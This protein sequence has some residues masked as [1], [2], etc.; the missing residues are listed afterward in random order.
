MRWAAA[1]ALVVLVLLVIGL[2][3]KTQGLPGAANAAALVSLIPLG[4]GL[5]GW[6]RNRRGA[7][8]QADEGTADLGQWL[9][10]IA[11]GKGLTRQD[12]RARMQGWSGEQVDAYLDGARRPEWAFM[13]AFIAVVAGREPWHREALERMIRPVWNASDAAARS[14]DGA[15]A[16]A[17][18]R[19][20]SR[21][22]REWFAALG[23]VVATRQVLRRVEISVR[24]HE[25]LA[26]ALGEM[27]ARLSQAVT[28]LAAQRDAQSRRQGPRPDGS[29]GE[30]S[31]GQAQ[32]GA[33]ELR[34]EQQETQRRLSEAERLRVATVQ[35][36]NVSEGQRHHAEQL[37][38]RVIAQAEQARR[39]LAQL[40]SHPEPIF[41]QDAEILQITDNP[42]N[43]LMGDTD[44][45]MAEEILDRVDSVL[46]DEA[47]TLGQLGE[48]L[49]GHPAPRGIARDGPGAPGRRIM[50]P[51][52]VAVAA[53][54]AIIAAGLLVTTN[55]GS[56]SGT[57]PGAGSRS[58]SYVLPLGQGSNFSYF[59]FDLG[60]Q[61]GSRA[62]A[63]VE[64]SYNL[65]EI[66]GPL[67]SI[68]VHYGIVQSDVGKQACYYAA[69]GST[70]GGT[71][72]SL[73]KGLRFCVL[74][75]SGVALMEI[76]QTPGNSGPLDLRE[77][78]WPGASP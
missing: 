76:T 44:R 69:D 70:E 29:R 49:T 64:A 43:V 65:S 33:A 17:G 11:D 51:R 16:A 13:A 78:D 73:Y 72:D 27:L 26:A 63:Q 55:I 52:L 68:Y 36:L 67:F 20:V 14:K 23:N 60:K 47:Q 21:E 28:S 71:L 5:A 75:S 34:E 10:T 40:D 48:D 39:R 30:G 22:G 18:K 37:K 7:Q 77:T 4:A 53:G 41:S 32:T 3:L 46:R 8:D 2:V 24:R 62:G 19:V 42:A 57:G 59:S 38:E 35:R 58:A 9:R 45:A 54:A 66:A 56:G 12:L 6:A 31:H 15:G 50:G 74:T 61:V 25:A 1:V